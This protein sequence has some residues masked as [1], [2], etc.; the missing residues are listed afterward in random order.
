MMNMDVVSAN[1]QTLR[2]TVNE[3]IKKMKE[4]ADANVSKAETLEDI[5]DMRGKTFKTADLVKLMEKYDTEAFAQFKKH[6]TFFDDGTWYHGGIPE[7]NK[8]LNKVQKGFKNETLSSEKTGTASKSNEARLSSKAQK[9]LNNL[10]KQYGDYDFFI[11]GKSDDLRAMVK[12]GTKEFSV[13]FSG[14]EI[15]RMANDEK[16]AKEKLGNMEQAVKMSEQINQ[17]NKDN[18]SG[19]EISKIGI[20]FHD[21]G[22]TSFFAELEKSSAKQ[23]E[24][25][26][27]NTEDKRA[28]TRGER[29]TAKKDIQKYSKNRTDTKRTAVEANSMESLLKKISEVNWDMV[30]AENIPARGGR[31]DFSV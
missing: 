29:N 15:E 22:T 3:K 6:A 16:Y 11:G 17:M 27:K 23:K 24:R 2:E 1:Y 26:E 25:I 9:F 7:L 13:I 19:A 8:W 18:L 14:A 30:K 21:D 28:E 10:R 31:Y 12:S 5:R 4:L 20:A